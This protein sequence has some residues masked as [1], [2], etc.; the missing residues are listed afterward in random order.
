[1]RKERKV[2]RT[3][4]IEKT[5]AEKKK[6]P[7][8][9]EVNEEKLKADRMEVEEAPKKVKKN[10]IE[11]DF[12]FTNP[13]AGDELSDVY[14]SENESEIRDDIEVDPDERM[15]NEVDND[16]AYVIPKPMSDMEKRRKMLNRKRKKEERAE[17]KA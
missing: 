10:K 11:E 12:K 9:T 4:L 7:Q 2:K 14:I 15:P 6:K 3:K 1:M 8:N 16:K 17:S 13:L 5:R